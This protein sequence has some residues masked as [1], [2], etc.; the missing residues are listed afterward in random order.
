MTIVYQT[1]TAGNSYSR[2]VV[3]PNAVFFAA[4]N[5]PTGLSISNSGVISGTITQAGRFAVTILARGAGGTGAAILDL[6]VDA[7][8]VPFI[9]STDVVSHDVAAAFSYQITASS[10]TAILSYGATNLPSGLTVN[11]ST[12][13]ITGT[14]TTTF[15][16]VFINI[17]ANVSATNANG[18]GNRDVIIRLQKR[19][20]I[21][22]SLSPIDSNVNEPITPYTITATNSPISF[23][24]SSLPP[25]LTVNSSTG[26][27]SGTPTIGNPYG[28]QINAFNGE[29]TGTATLPFAVLGPPAITSGLFITNEYLQPF[30]Y[31][32]TANGYPPPTYSVPDL[33]IGLSTNS[34]TGLISGTLN[35]PSFNTPYTL[36]AT[37]SAG[38]ATASAAVSTTYTLSGIRVCPFI[39]KLNGVYSYLVETPAGLGTNQ[40]TVYT[41]SDKVTWTKTVIGV[42]PNTFGTSQPPNFLYNA[43]FGVA[44]MR[45]V[46]LPSGE[47]RIILYRASNYSPDPANQ[48]RYLSTTNGTSWSTG[49]FN[50]GPQSNYFR[51]TYVLNKFYG[52]GEDIVPAFRTSSDGIN[53]TTVAFNM[54]G[55][56]SIQYKPMSFIDVIREKDGYAFYSIYSTDFPSGIPF[57]LRSPD[58]INWTKV[59]VN[60]ATSGYYLTAVGPLSASPSS[61]VLFFPQRNLS[62][63][64]QY[65]RTTD[66]VTFTVHTYP[67]PVN[68]LTDN[69]QSIDGKFWFPRGIFFES[70][71]WYVSSDGI[72]WALSPTSPAP[73]DVGVIESIY[74]VG[75]GNG[76]IG[77]DLLSAFPVISPSNFRFSPTGEICY[78]RGLGAAQIQPNI[79]YVN[80]TYFRYFPV[81]MKISNSNRTSW[82]ESTIYQ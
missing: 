24:A 36:T 81:T 54:P 41:S 1:V 52:Y 71:T 7:P 28:I 31:Q 27:I 60:V 13:L 79:G 65:Y 56:Q 30:N 80:D 66:L 62:P 32:I 67:F 59:P 15:S 63:N 72:N 75:G 14:V 64:S 2:T 8:P 58:L 19:P 76:G 33:S 45:P 74:Q 22:S 57:F 16:G 23:S 35:G 47:V 37:N 40:F 51:G 61:P 50:T 26:V 68:E 34:S 42:F 39:V 11:T 70:S 6:T 10:P 82:T 18:T 49:T 73:V 29:L 3:A 77:Y 17:T 78:T 12:G 5:L 20:V 21:T 48:Q 44:P 25:G 43:S 53:W 55:V 38:T 69:I 9:T 4:E 46:V